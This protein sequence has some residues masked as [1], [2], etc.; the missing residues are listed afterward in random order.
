VETVLQ[1]VQVIALIAVTV[2]CVY[3][4]VVLAAMRRDLSD[5]AQRSKPVLENLAFI[6]EK[7]KSTAQ[8]I[9][10]HVDIVKSSLTSFKNVAD[11]V[12]ELE[13]RVQQR[14]EEPIMQVASI[15]GT[16]VSSVGVFFERFRPRG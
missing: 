14:I 7:L 9:D 12:L 6:T 5:I 10:D 4:V 1:L 2:L 15:I 13:E 16:I 11:N 3:L 8:K